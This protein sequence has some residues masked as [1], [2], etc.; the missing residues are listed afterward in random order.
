MKPSDILIERKRQVD[1]LLNDFPKIMGVE[2][3]NHFKG[4]FRNGGFTDSGLVKWKPRKSLRDSR[5][6]ILVKTGDLKNSIRVKNYFKNGVTI[7]SD[8]EYGEYHNMGT[9]RLPQ[10]KFIG[11]SSRL[12]T[13]LKNILRERFKIIFR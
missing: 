9:N 12:N 3:I 1:N 2:A 8:S 4:S 7:S 13:R 5:R 11:N 6:A 10:R